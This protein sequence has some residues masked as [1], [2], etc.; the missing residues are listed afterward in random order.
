MSQELADVFDDIGNPL[1]S[2]EDV[3]HAQNWAFTRIYENELALQVSGNHC[4]YQLTF[5]W[6]EEYGAMQ[7]FCECDLSI[8]EK[9]DDLTARALQTIN[10]QLWL[11][12][13]DIADKSKAPCFRYTSL[14]RGGLH[15]SGADHL[16]NLIDIAL[17]ECERYSAVFTLLSQSLY[18]DNDLLDLALAENGGR[19]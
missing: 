7:L 16:Q 2:V 12:H 19:A 13:F 1:D 17:A 6:Q 8:P 3:L 15:M 18:L 14:L 11:G 5:I 10:E 9:R 4:T